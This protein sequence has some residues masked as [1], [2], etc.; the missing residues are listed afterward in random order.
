METKRSFSWLR[1]PWILIACCA[2][3]LLLH[4]GMA[5]PEDATNP[6]DQIKELLQER[7]VLAEEIENLFRMRYDMAETSLGE[8]IHAKM[9]VLEVRLELAESSQERI[10]IHGKLVE[11]AEEYQAFVRQMVEARETAQIDLLQAEDRVLQ[12][13]IALERA[14][15]MK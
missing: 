13:R 9:A 15:I 3:F 1:R 5:V 12:R 8:L 14:K 2:V 4:R 7:L 11:Q 10:E 6:P